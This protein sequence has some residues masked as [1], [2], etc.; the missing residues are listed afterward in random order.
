MELKVKIPHRCELCKRQLY[1]NHY[2]YWKEKYYC[3]NHWMKKNPL[4]RT[5]K[6]TI[7]TQSKE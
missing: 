5:K 1:I 3:E 6:K 4:L 2:V 7:Q